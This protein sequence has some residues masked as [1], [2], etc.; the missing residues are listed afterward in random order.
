MSAGLPADRIPQAKKLFEHYD[1]LGSGFIDQIEL[2]R[3]CH[4]MDPGVTLE[5]VATSIAEVGAKEGLD[6][7]KWYLWIQSMFGEENDVDYRSG[8]CHSCHPP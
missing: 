2:L 6:E 1:T 4:A 7:E 8:E 3:L 5:G